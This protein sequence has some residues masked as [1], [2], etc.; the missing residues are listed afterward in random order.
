MR[1]LRD[2]RER[3]AVVRA[4]GAPEGEGGEAYY[5]QLSADGLF[6]ASGYYRMARDQ[7]ARFRA[8]VADDV[9]GPEL[10]VALAGLPR[11]LEIGGRELTTAPRGYPRDHPRI[12]LL[13]H[14]SLT[15]ARAFGAP[16]WLGTRRALT[17]VAET[18]R[19]AAPMH[20][21]LAAN[22]GPSNELPPDAR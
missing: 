13:Q 6:V 12:A 10:E 8:A 21:W 7:L 16:A 14:K 22:V 2:G 9:S 11:T 3:R 20:A 17:R 15:A 19:A 5:V 4:G 18:W 1:E